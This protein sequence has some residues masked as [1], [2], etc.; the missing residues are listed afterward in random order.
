[1]S[2]L[3]QL[4]KLPVE[5]RYEIYAYVLKESEP[6][7]IRRVTQLSKRGRRRKLRP[8][9]YSARIIVRKKPM[10]SL[11]QHNE[12]LFVC[13][14]I[15][16]EAVEVLYSRNRFNFTNSLTLQYFLEISPNACKYLCRIVVCESAVGKSRSL[17]KALKLL[18]NSNNLRS[19]QLCSR[20][21]FYCVYCGSADGQIHRLKKL[22]D[23]CV[24][25]LR[26]LQ[27]TIQARGLKLD[28][29]DV[30]S[31]YLHGC[32]CCPWRGIRRFV[33][34]NRR[35]SQGLLCS[36]P[37]R[38]SWN[39]SDLHDLWVKTFKKELSERLDLTNA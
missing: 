14:Q 38:T 12:V 19:L 6:I 29:L 17:D 32:H 5:L 36:C 15:S 13:K 34:L 39:L 1:M 3:G 26:S 9:G 23:R 4:G 35:S 8:S 33:S 18:A 16:N 30:A 27:S 24:P 2:G 10:L 22:A 37:P 28:I 20:Q 21:F 25:L 31:M 11:A 7:H